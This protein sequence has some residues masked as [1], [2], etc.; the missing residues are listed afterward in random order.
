ML[1]ISKEQIK[2]L[3]DTDFRNLVG[4]LC[5]LELKSKEISTVYVDYGGNQTA[6][7]GGIDV[8][9]DILENTSITGYIQKNKTGYQ[10]KATKMNP[11][12][13]KDEMSP[14]G[15]LRKS[16]KELINGAYIIISNEWIVNTF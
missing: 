13:I 12:K 4:L 6:S 5:E 15:M 11:K 7:D 14:K 3:D 8:I 1:Q 10:V 16:I 2:R 9:V